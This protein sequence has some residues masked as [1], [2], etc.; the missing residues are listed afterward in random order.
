MN[1]YAVSVMHTPSRF[2]VP[3][4]HSIS[5]VMHCS[6]LTRFDCLDGGEILPSILL[7]G[8]WDKKLSYPATNGITYQNGGIAQYL[9]SQLMSKGQANKRPTQSGN[10]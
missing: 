1:G 9:R 3:L 5:R 4:Y 2:D 10:N 8:L 6:L 7:T